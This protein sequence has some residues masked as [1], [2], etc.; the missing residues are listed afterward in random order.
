VISDVDDVFAKKAVD[1][2]NTKSYNVKY[3]KT[4]VRSVAQVN[5]A[6]DFTVKEFGKVDI[7]VNNAGVYRT[8]KFTDVTE[9]LWD[10]ALDINLKGAFFF[11]QAVARQMIEQGH[12]G[13]I[14]NISSNAGNSMETS[15]GWMIQYVASKGG[16]NAITK[17][18]ARELK[19]HGIHINA[20]VPGG[21][22]SVG[23]MVQERTPEIME[24]RNANP[25][26]PME[27]SDE[28][29]RVVYMMATEMSDYM[30]GSIVFADG[31]TNLGFR[32]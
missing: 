11:V 12:G 28:V 8:N 23:G 5:A 24:V 17:S 30:D 29:A 9:E 25:P 18:L 6:V 14:V 15:Y 2:F 22:L 10:T 26:A 19:P 20:V 16:I 27:D 31:G 1:F 3:I 32:K 21:M 4:D 7:L 13:R